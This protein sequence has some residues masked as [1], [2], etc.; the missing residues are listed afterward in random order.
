M[1][2]GA[3]VYDGHFQCAF[4]PCVQRLPFVLRCHD[5]W[6]VGAHSLFVSKLDMN[7]TNVPICVASGIPLPVRHKAE[8]PLLGA[9]HSRCSAAPNTVTLFAQIKMI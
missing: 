6:R 7:G 8:A 5:F 3:I 1:V 4:R 9:A 2:G